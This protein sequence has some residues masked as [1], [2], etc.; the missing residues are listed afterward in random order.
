[1]KKDENIMGAADKIGITL[2]DNHIHLL[3]GEIN[4]ENIDEAIRW[5]IYE[6]LSE[7][8]KTLSLYINSHGG[9]LSEAFGLI[10]IMRN[11]KHPI[12]TIGLG[13]VC[14]AAFL[15]FASGTKGERY[16]S[17]NTSIM[18]HQYT[19]DLQGKYHDMKAYIHEN[20]LT[21]LRMIS[22]LQECTDLEPRA[23]KTKFLP[24]SDVWF[25]AEELVEL[26]IADQIL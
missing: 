5:I 18:C 9:D 17:K 20:E 13:S 26:G 10:D 1:M 25:T 23:I 24:P 22:L 3:S 2:L 11:S 21:N 7:T 8:E 6:N 14:S 4:E 15:V 16:I 19:G 12:Q